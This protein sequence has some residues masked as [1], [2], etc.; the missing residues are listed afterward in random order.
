MF[1]RATLILTRKIFL[2][3]NKISRKKLQTKYSRTLFGIK[4]LSTNITLFD[5]IKENI[6]LYCVI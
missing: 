3:A 4:F 2:G 5:V 1:Q 6:I